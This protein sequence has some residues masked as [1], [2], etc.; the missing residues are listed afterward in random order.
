MT[1]FPGG[2]YA[3]AWGTSFSSAIVAL[4]HDANGGNMIPV[5]YFQAAQ[6]LTMSA[7]H[8]QPLQL[9]AGRLDIDHAMTCGPTG[10]S[11]NR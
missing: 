7:L 2:P 4:L 11:C 10:G 9:G 1:S 5:N 8:V 6:A 3:A